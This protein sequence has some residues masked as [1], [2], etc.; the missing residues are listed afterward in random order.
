MAGFD[1]AAILAQVGAGQEPGDVD[2]NLAALA[3]ALA[4]PLR[5][6]TGTT[7]PEAAAQLQEETGLPAGMLNGLLSWGMQRAAQ[8][9]SDAP[10]EEA[11]QYVSQLV[12]AMAAVKQWDAAD[13][14][15]GIFEVMTEGGS[16]L[17]RL[18]RAA[19]DMGTSIEGL[20][21]P[22]GSLI[23]PETDQE[24]DYSAVDPEPEAPDGGE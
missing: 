13:V 19:I 15:D 8:G 18:Y 7:T 20:P 11:W 2:P 3:E 17:P 4:Y 10:N 16:P 6:G 14:A 22:D 1:A 12:T 23:E 9:L 24:P 21:D 5:M